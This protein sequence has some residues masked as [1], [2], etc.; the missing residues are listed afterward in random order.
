MF[1][2][3]Q[4]REDLQIQMNILKGN[5]L[6]LKTRFNKYFER[7]KS[8]TSEDY[9]DLIHSLR[10]LHKVMAQVSWQLY[11]SDLRPKK[12]KNFMN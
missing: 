6:M 9:I 11:V 3:P 4:T 5:R 2:K 7:M 8:K 12:K 1:V 10:E